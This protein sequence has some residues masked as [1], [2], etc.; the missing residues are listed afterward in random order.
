MTLL[1]HNH[2][3]KVLK[4]MYEARERL[5][6]PD[7]PNINTP[8]ARVGLLGRE[9][10]RRTIHPSAPN[11][12]HP[13]PVPTREQRDVVQMDGRRRDR[14]RSRGQSNSGHKHGG[15]SNSGHEEA[16]DGVRRDRGRKF[17]PG[18]P[19]RAGKRCATAT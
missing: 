12:P 4:M 17:V 14:D 1:Q 7:R 15:D 2:G 6:Q 3:G 19:A 9:M 8:Y 11:V 16:K 18:A 13:S 10:D 5:A